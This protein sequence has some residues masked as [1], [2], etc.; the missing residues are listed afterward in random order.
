MAHTSDHD[1]GRDALVAR[2]MPVPP[3]EWSA[4]PA[5]ERS[6]RA[7]YATV[8]VLAG[9]DAQRA[10]ARALDRSP[11]GEAAINEAQ[12]RVTALVLRSMLGAVR[13]H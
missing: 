13:G 12:V 7:L 1:P 3:P 9:L 4:L 8:S 6:R 2:H 10:W 5:Y 11:E